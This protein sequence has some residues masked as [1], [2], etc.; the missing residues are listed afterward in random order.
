M[1]ITGQITN[2]QPDGG[3]NGTHGYI[4]TFQ[5]TI[6]GQ[7]GPV[8]GQIGSKSQVYPKN[9]GETITVELTS[10]QHGNRLKAINAQYANQGGGQQNQQQPHQ[11]APQDRQDKPDWDKIAEGKVRHGVICA[12]IQSG[13]LVCTS[14]QNATAWVDFIMGR[15]TQGGMDQGQQDQYNNADGELGPSGDD[16]PF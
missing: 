13:Q 15:N 9:V 10:G 14:E 2:I 3:Y 16:I 1:Q 4:N 11:N 6:Q 8:T 7:N 12:G 5:M